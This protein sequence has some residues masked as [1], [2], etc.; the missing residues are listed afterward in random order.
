MRLAEGAKGSVLVATV[1]FD[2]RQLVDFTLHRRPPA[3]LWML[4]QGIPRGS[5]Q[6]PEALRRNASLPA[7]YRKRTRRF[8]RRTRGSTSPTPPRCL[9][10][11]Y[12]AHDPGHSRFGDGQI[13]LELFDTAAANLRADWFRN[14]RTRLRDRWLARVRQ[15]DG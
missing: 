7:G 8:H 5:G 12:L 2:G 10:V 13:P 9:E 11:R 15:A 1:A 4:A 14:A 3:R 6:A